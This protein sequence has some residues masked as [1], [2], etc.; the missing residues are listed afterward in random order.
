MTSRSSL[1]DIARHVG[2]AVSTVSIALR[3]DQRVERG[4][5]EKILAGAKKLRYRPN[6]VL[7]A[8][9]SHQ[10]KRAQKGIPLAFLTQDEASIGSEYRLYL[11]ERK[12]AASLGYDFQHYHIPELRKLRDPSRMLYQRGIEGIVLSYYANAQTLPPIDWNL[13]AVAALGG[14]NGL[15]GLPSFHRASVDHFSVV[16]RCWSEAQKAGYRR[17]G[18]V[19]QEHD[20]L[21]VDD[22]MRHSAGLYC[23]TR[24]APRDKVPILRLHFGDWK[25]TAPILR[26]W[27][28][29]NKPD[30]VIG[31]QAFVSWIIEEVGWK[32]PQ[33][34]AFIA[35]NLDLSK[36]GVAGMEDLAGSVTSAA[37]DLI[38][39]QIR[40][41]IRG[42]PEDPRMVVIGS[43]WIPGRSFP[44][45]RPPNASPRRAGGGAWRGGERRRENR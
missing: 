15:S 2:C 8:L 9:A 40:H 38:D 30:L 13:F 4:T 29:K 14:E 27:L 6:P 32:I 12:H 33:Q 41:R 45:K 25:L 22:I 11:D 34:V 28:D 37:V 17:I 23:Q 18:I 44:A 5:R 39:Q 19:L 20:P 7:A 24:V 21:L 35:I 10:F 26:A 42:I 1:S 16:R 36:K 31:L 3:G 43:R